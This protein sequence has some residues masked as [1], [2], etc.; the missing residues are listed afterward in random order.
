MDGSSP[1]RHVLQPEQRSSRLRVGRGIHGPQGQLG[2]T[3]LRPVACWPGGEGWWGSLEWFSSDTQSSAG[4]QGSL[5]SQSLCLGERGGGASRCWNSREGQRPGA[6]SQGERAGPPCSPGMGLTTDSKGTARG[7][8][9]RREGRRAWGT[10]GEFS[11]ELAAVNT[12]S[13]G[14]GVA[15][16]VQWPHALGPHRD[17]MCACVHTMSLCVLVVS[18]LEDKGMMESWGSERGRYSGSVLMPWTPLISGDQCWSLHRAALRLGGLAEDSGGR[19]GRVFHS[20]WGFRG[21]T[22]PF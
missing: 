12:R 3:A 18:G 21:G 7:A 22:A 15:C 16:G 5:I 13:P 2:H 11:R 9:A 20:S 14:L 4:R 6:V 10:H 19:G 1:P 17:P 8:K